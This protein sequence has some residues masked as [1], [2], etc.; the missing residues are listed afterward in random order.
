MIV[1]SRSRS[2]LITD[3]RVCSSRKAGQ[4]VLTDSAHG[5]NLRRNGLRMSELSLS[6]V[7]GHDLVMIPLHSEVTRPTETRD[8]HFCKIYSCDQRQPWI[9]KLFIMS[10]YFLKG[11]YFSIKHPSPPDYKRFQHCSLSSAGTPSNAGFSRKILI[12]RSMPR[13]NNMYDAN[14]NTPDPLLMNPK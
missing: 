8:G 2:T 12:T 3:Y 11:G 10:T 1:C 5:D 9:E 7:V 6:T 14:H 4:A 13:P